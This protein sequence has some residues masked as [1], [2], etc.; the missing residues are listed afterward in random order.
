MPKT[1]S[2]T[3]AKALFGTLLKWI[4]EHDDEVIV[5]HYNKPAAV[6]MPFEEYEKVRELRHRERRREALTTLQ[7]LRA[8]VRSQNEDLDEEDAYQLAGFSQEAITELI[9]GAGEEEGRQA[10]P[11]K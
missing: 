6:L 7:A 11:G 5:E 8:E 1:V 10:T 3:E 2:S 9:A 4:G